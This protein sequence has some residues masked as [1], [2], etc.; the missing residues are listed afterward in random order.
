MVSDKFRPSEVKHPEPKQHELLE[1]GQDVLKQ[2]KKEI[3]FTSHTIKSGENL[4]EICQQYGIPLKAL[5]AVNQHELDPKII[6]KDGKVAYGAPTYHV[7]DKLNIPSQADV[8]N[9]VKYFEAWTK[10]IIAKQQLEKPESPITSGKPHGAQPEKPHSKTQILDEAHLAARSAALMVNVTSETQYNRFHTKVEGQGAIESGWDLAKRVLKLGDNSETTE[11]DFANQRGLVQ[12]LIKA[13][14]NE[15]L[16]QFENLYKQCTGKQYN[17]ADFKLAYKKPEK[18]AFPDLAEMYEKSQQEGLKGAKLVGAAGLAAS[19]FVP[20]VGVVTGPLA[21][22]M[23]AGAGLAVIGSGLVEYSNSGM[24][25]QKLL[26]GA[27]EAAIVGASVPV[28]ISVGLVGEGLAGNV[29]IKTAAHGATTVAKA[30]LVGEVAAATAGGMSGGAA[31]GGMIGGGHAIIED[32][33]KGKFDPGHVAFKTAEGSVY[34]AVIG[35][36]LGAGGALLKNVRH[37]S[38]AEVE[39]QARADAI[40]S[41]VSAGARAGAG[42]ATETAPLVSSEVATTK[43]LAQAFNKTAEL[44]PQ[45]PSKGTTQQPTDLSKGTQPTDVSKGT[46]SSPPAD[47]GKTATSTPDVAK[48]TTPQTDAKTIPGDW[49]KQIPPLEKKTGDFPTSKIDSPETTKTFPKPPTDAKPTP[50]QSASDAGKT[51]SGDWNKG[52][53]LDGPPQQKQAKPAEV[54]KSISPEEAWQKKLDKLASDPLVKDLKPLELK[55]GWQG[56]EY[57]RKI[58]GRTVQES[59]NPKDGS[60][61]FTEEYKD[62]AGV[63]HREVTT[64]SANGQEVTNKFRI[65]QG[66][67]GKQELIPVSNKWESHLAELRRDRSISNLEEIPMGNNWHKVRYDKSNGRQV[68]EAVKDDGSRYSKI[69]YTDHRG[70]PNREVST[71]NADGHTATNKFTLD[72]NGQWKH[73]GKTRTGEVP[74]ASIPNGPAEPSSKVSLAKPPQARPLEKLQ[75]AEDRIKAG[76]GW[77]DDKLESLQSDSNILSAKEVQLKKGWKAVEYTDASGAK[78]TEAY[79]PENGT[80]HTTLDYVS[81]GVRMKVETLDVPKDGYKLQRIQRQNETKASELKR[82]DPRYEDLPPELE[83]ITLDTKR[84]TITKS[85]KTRTD[86]S[87]FED[88]HRLHTREE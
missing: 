46:V 48:G 78:V 53:T 70:V 38:A 13:A 7:G 79:N 22:Q 55:N 18:L 31:A 30:G 36:P 62:G 1:K 54:T 85:G 23:A 84:T 42:T 19:A 65:R 29:A 50:T 87:S 81:K 34:G 11:R 5:Y 37:V 40:A 14:K 66:A 47:A 56:V 83:W 75:S 64:T 74:E 24:I 72:Q 61:V 80:K 4:T 28:A 6:V 88:D 39:A 76:K 82:K 73:I 86:Y 44:Q 9:A 43:D 21:V 49:S 20:G 57:Q 8:P 12:Q 71:T 10:S 45:I 41:E 2:A 63:P 67:D 51:S 16:T 58:G 59:Y 33:K 25:D 17:P 68:E 35:A 32:T 77:I 52:S 69:E 26:D 15:N 27:P 60:K 3:S